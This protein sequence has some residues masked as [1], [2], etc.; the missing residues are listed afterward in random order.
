MS[1]GARKKHH[2]SPLRKKA[3]TS[4]AGLWPSSDTMAAGSSANGNTSR[5]SRS[6]GLRKSETR[7]KNTRYTAAIWMAQNPSGPA[8]S[9]QGSGPPLQPS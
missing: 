4:A 3:G 7:Q 1:S 6:H 2:M 5:S 9:A 8:Q